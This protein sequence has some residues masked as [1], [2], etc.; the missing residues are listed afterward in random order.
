MKHSINDPR[1]WTE[2]AEEM[3]VLAEDMAN[4]EPKAMLLRNADEYDEMAKRAALR[5]GERAS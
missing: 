1:H 2:R 5:V 4:P 3:R